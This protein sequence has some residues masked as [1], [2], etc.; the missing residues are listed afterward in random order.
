MAKGIF[1]LLLIGLGFSSLAAQVDLGTGDRPAKV[2]LERLLMDDPRGIQETVFQTRLEKFLVTGKDAEFFLKPNSTGA[3]GSPMREGLRCYELTNA[4]AGY[5][6]TH[7]NGDSNPRYFRPLNHRT[8]PLYVY[9]EDRNNQYWVRIPDPERIYGP[10]YGTAIERIK[11][12]VLRYKGRTS[13]KGVELQF[14]AQRWEFP[15]EVDAMVERTGSN[16]DFVGGSLSGREIEARRLNSSFLRFRLTNNS[17]RH[18]FLQYRNGQPDIAHLSRFASDKDWR[19]GQHDMD[20]DSARFYDG[21]N[22]SWEMLPP[23]ASLEFDVKGG[24]RQPLI[25]SA[26]FYINENRDFWDPVQIE[27]PYPAKPVREFSEKHRPP[28]RR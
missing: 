8:I 16:Y 11:N 24:C 13:F 4:Q 20:I 22:L 6:V 12:A 15:D 2:D 26:R 27:A 10:F 9:A 1:T 23:G 7:Y 3:C 19:V 18:V 14:V 17:G 5:M 28:P 25:C 21:Q